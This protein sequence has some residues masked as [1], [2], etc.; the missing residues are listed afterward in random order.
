MVKITNQILNE[1]TTGGIK[2]NI[3]DAKN[4]IKQ[5]KQYL[6]CIYELLIMC[7]DN[8]IKLTIDSDNISDFNNEHLESVVK[9]VNIYVTEIN[10]IVNNAQYNGRTL[11]ADTHSTTKSI[12]YRIAQKTNYR[13]NNNKFNDFTLALPLVGI[14]ELDI[15][16]Y[17]TDFSNLFQM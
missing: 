3:L 16:V 4:T 5:M 7:Q 17:K 6:M 2:Y 11:L 14:Q 15:E 1:I 12:V 8:L 10:S 13:S 9:C